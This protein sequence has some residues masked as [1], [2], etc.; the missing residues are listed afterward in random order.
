MQAWD[1]EKAVYEDDRSFLPR[2]SPVLCPLADNA[3]L[4][5]L[6]CGSR[7]KYR[8]Y[9]FVKDTLEIL[10]RQSRAFKVA[11]PATQISY[12]EDDDG[13]RGLLYL[14]SRRDLL[15][16][17]LCLLI[18]DWRHPT[19]PQFLLCVVVIAQIELGPDQDYGNVGCMMLNLG[20]PL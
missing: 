19:F 1:E 14:R 11:R 5:L 13:E 6:G 2:G 15:L 4:L 7:L 8:P 10:L 16:Y 17:L 20:E 12:A 3:G 18:G 9:S